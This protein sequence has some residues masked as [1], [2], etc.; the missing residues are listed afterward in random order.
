MRCLFRDKMS[1]KIIL[2]AKLKTG[3]PTAKSVFFFNALSK[4]HPMMIDF[5]PK[6]R[7][8]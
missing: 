7:A 3:T 1:Q 4:K 5:A 6:I 8:M 2:L